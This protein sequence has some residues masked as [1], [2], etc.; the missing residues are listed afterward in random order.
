[1][2]KLFYVSK[3]CVEKYLIDEIV[4]F[5]E[6][7]LNNLLKREIKIGGSGVVREGGRYDLVKC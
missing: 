4:K 7:F 3:G 1:M 5:V 2:L 6:M